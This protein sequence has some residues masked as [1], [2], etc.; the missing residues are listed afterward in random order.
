MRG[1][2]TRL[3]AASPGASGYCVAMR[4]TLST[5]LRTVGAL[6]I[7][8]P[9]LITIC[10]IAIVQ[11][12]L[13]APQSGV[14]WA[15]RI[16][17]RTFIRLAGG[18]VLVHGAENS[19]ACPA[20]V[21]VSNHESNLDPFVIMDALP[22][23]AIRFVIKRPI[24][25]IPIFGHALALTGNVTV[26]RR[27]GSGDVKRLQAG[28]D[29]RDPSVSLLFF[30]EGTRSRDGAFR[31]FKKGAFATAIAEGLPVLP[32]AV[33]G[34]Y[35]SLPPYARTLRQSA[36]AVEVGAPIP[37]KGLSHADRTA[38]LERAQKSVAE[39]RATARARVR[40]AGHDPGG[41]D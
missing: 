2:G 6:L 34:T 20:Y 28:M 9:L 10:G 12:L 24:M 14:Q 30:A 13:G 22:D 35:A 25:R 19:G 41:L 36:L 7:L 39:L 3:A 5:L 32:I 18:P 17:S 37:T 26:D 29:S 4:R 23:L 27:Q 11:A 21:V 33:A 8:P 31:A 38:L 1:S 15:Y 16:F 40:A